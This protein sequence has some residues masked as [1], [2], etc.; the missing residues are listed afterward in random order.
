MIIRVLKL[1]QS[2]N[3]AACHAYAQKFS[4]HITE[5]FLRELHKTLSMSFLQVDEAFFDNNTLTV[6]K[7]EATCVQPNMYLAHKF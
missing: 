7:V 3:K 2:L 1:I 5:G 4:E 6:A